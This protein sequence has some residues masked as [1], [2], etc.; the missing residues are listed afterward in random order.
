M[1]GNPFRISVGPAAANIYDD[2]T[3]SRLTV[4]WSF[5]A[6]DYKYRNGEIITFSI[7][8]K[9]EKSELF[10]IDTPDKKLIFKN[11]AFFAIENL[12]TVPSANQAVI[13]L[14]E[15]AEEMV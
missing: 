14:Q 8:P 1:G 11:L 5:D 3:K 2:D 12:K 10:K 7:G 4:D 9:T 13:K 15:Y 6:I